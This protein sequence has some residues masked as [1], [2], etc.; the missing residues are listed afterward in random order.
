MVPLPS[1]REAHSGPGGASPHFHRFHGAL[2][3]SFNSYWGGCY[4]WNGSY[5]YWD[6]DYY[7][8]DRQ[9]FGRYQRRFPVDSE[10]EVASNRAVFFFPP[11]PPPLGT[12]PPPGSPETGRNEAPAELSPFINDPF[13]APLGTRLQARD[14]S[15]KQLQQLD[16]LRQKKTEL[17]EE[18]RSEIQWTKDSPAAIRLS[19]LEKLSRKQ[20]PSIRQ[21]ETEAEQLRADLLYHGL[22]GMFW[23]SGDWNEGRPWMLG[24]GGL[25]RPRRETLAYEFKVVRAAIFYQE[26][27]SPAQRRLLREVAMELQVEAF[28]PTATTLSDESL[29]AFQPETARIRLSPALRPELATKLAA[30][31]KQKDALKSELRGALYRLDV[32]TSSQR[33]KALREF[34]TVQAPQLESLDVLAEELRGLLRPEDLLG[35][36]ASEPQPKEVGEAENEYHDAVLLPGLSPEQRR[37]LYD[38]AMEKLSLPLPAG[39]S[40]SW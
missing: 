9:R 25:N 26:G 21:L 29:L 35:R 34:A 32:A 14:L 8:T 22:V 18:L 23:G 24:Q 7:S 13:Y 6:G 30:F 19:D 1:Q 38:D 20:T 5:Y 3:P 16:L 2:P 17:R 27:L 15:K 12:P 11:V 36:S 39:E 37:L 31:K 10:S 28:R 40:V 33:T 4:Y